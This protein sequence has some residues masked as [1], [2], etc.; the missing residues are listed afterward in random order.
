MDLLIDECVPASVTEIFA[1]HK[2][3]I[4]YVSRELGQ[5][6]P[7]RLVAETADEN[8][9]VLVTWNYRDFKRLGITRRPPNNKQQYRHAGMIS[10]ICDED[11]GKRRAEQVIASIE[12]E[13]G[14]ALKRPDKRLLIAI[15]IDRFI[16]HY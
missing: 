12:F 13:Y 15:Y 16:V 14:Q 5:K 9:L 3:S 4:V 7:D 11:Q 10:F 2:H 1:K 8:S 6:T